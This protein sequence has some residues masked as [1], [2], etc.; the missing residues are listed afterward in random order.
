MAILHN[1]CKTEILQS[2]LLTQTDKEIIEIIENNSGEYFD[3]Q[4]GKTGKAEI[5]LNLSRMRTSLLNWY[6]FKDNA[7]ILEIGCGY[8]ALTGLL[9]DKAK[10]VTAV[11]ESFLRAR[12]VQRRYQSRENLDIYVRPVREVL[13]TQ[14]FDYIILTGY[15]EEMGMSE[16]VQNTYVD[17]LKLL[18]DAINPEGEILLACDNRFGLRYFCGVPAPG[19]KAV[20]DGIRNYPNGS[21]VRLF[22][23]QELLNYISQAGL[24]FR[25]YYPLP[26]YKLTQ[27]VYSDEYLPCESIRDRVISYYPEKESLIAAE[28]DIYDDIIQNKVLPFF[29]NSF[30]AVCKLQS[31]KEYPVFATV[32]TDREESHAFATVIKNNDVVEKKVLF[33]SANA[34]LST[35]YNNLKELE[36]H[37]VP[38]VPVHLKTGKLVMPQIKSMNLA[39]YLTELIKKDKLAFENMIEQLYQLVLQSS[40]VVSIREC[41]GEFQSIPEEEIGPVLK[42]VYLDMIPY[43]CFYC[44]GKYMFYDQEFIKE[45]YPAKYALFRTLRY[46]YFYIPDAEEY[47]PLI[48]FKKKYFLEKLWSIFEAEEGSFTEKNRN[49]DKNQL[50]YSW[51]EVD[52]DKI[53]GRVCQK[54][55]QKNEVKEYDYR[56]DEQLKKVKQINIDTLSYFIKICE[57]NNLRYCAVYGSLLGAVRHKGFIPWDDDVDVAMPRKDYNR[58]CKLVEGGLLEKPYFFQTPENDP[59]CF[60]GGYGKLRNSNTTQMEYRHREKKCNQGIGIDVFPLDNCFA[61]EENRI[62]HINKINWYQQLLLAKIYGEVEP[63][64]K[65]LP[66]KKKKKL[67]LMSKLFSHKWLCKGLKKTLESCKDDTGKLAIL[68]RCLQPEEQKIFDAADFEYRILKPFEDIVISVPIGYNKWL[69]ENI[70]KNYKIYPPKSQRKPHQNVQ[71][72][73]EKSYVIHQREAE[74]FKVEKNKKI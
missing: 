43:N 8:G 70:G 67:F 30:L 21:K 27:V 18:K 58:F 53:Y 69:C 15:L 9:C 37:G 2:D 63:K 3:E 55:P 47:I 71:Y 1:F 28:D 44:E 49:K 59:D 52:K 5:F 11:E 26:D 12:I 40:E 13:K 24:Q 32:S 10:H 29:A 23:R 64:I 36:A 33:P 65:K 25:L 6:D 4:A 16:R 57:E 41:K 35:I 74:Q 73:T 50:F 68:A 38:I 61:E 7:E 14:K 56:N 34:I 39:D 72:D 60:Y 51:T 42:K 66:K 46:M 48:Y 20:F 19:T 17:F 22:S 31:D 62:K 54:L 45:C